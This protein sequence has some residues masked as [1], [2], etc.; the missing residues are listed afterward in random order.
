MRNVINNVCERER[1][2]ERGRELVRINMINIYKER[3]IESEEV[4]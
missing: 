4:I 1:E 3:D 2:R